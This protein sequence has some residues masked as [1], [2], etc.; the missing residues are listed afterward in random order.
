[1]N[2]TLIS[3]INNSYL[4]KYSECNVIV[5][6]ELQCIIDFLIENALFVRKYSAYCYF[7]RW[8]INPFG[9]SYVGAVYFLTAVAAM[10]HG[11]HVVLQWLV[12]DTISL[13][14]SVLAGPWVRKL[15]FK[16]SPGVTTNFVFIF[17]E[18]W[19]ASS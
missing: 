17:S 15:L 12:N 3:L 10:L 1:L 14:I 9:M 16:Y 18:G 5:V 7:K 11:S 8:C 4:V 19:A 13:G 6:S 2:L